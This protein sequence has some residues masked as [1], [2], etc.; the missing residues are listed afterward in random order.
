MKQFITHSVHIFRNINRTESNEEYS[1][2]SVK[3]L[4]PFKDFAAL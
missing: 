1:F 4:V 3:T 2:N